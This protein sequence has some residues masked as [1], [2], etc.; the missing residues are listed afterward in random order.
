[1]RFACQL[2]WRQPMSVP[3][4]NNGL[5]WAVLNFF[6]VEYSWLNAREN[7]LRRASSQS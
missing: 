1:V 3:V 4:E 5:Q 2:I 6:R 7:S